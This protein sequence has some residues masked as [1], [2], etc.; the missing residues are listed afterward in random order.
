[1]KKC[2]T[3]LIIREMQ[4]NTMRYHSIPIRMATVFF[5]KKTGAGEN[6]K[7]SELLG[8]VGG[9]VKWY[10]CWKTVWQFHKK[11][12]IDYNKIH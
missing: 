9:N 2:S 10:S 6:V 11:F 5:K 1:M 4:I 8:T 3:S 7:K 12:N